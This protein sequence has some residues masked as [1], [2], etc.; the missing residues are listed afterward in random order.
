MAIP[1]KIFCFV[2]TAFMTLSHAAVAQ[3][4]DLG[5]VDEFLGS[6]TWSSEFSTATSM[7]GSW[8]E[9]LPQGTC[10]GY[11]LRTD[12][13]AA[14]GENAVLS[15]WLGNNPEPQKSTLTQSVWEA[16]RGNFI[17]MDFT[18]KQ[19]YGFQMTVHSIE[20][21]TFQVTLNGTPTTLDARRVIAS[22]VNGANQHLGVEYVVVR[23]TRGLGQLVFMRETNDS[24]VEA[25][26]TRL[27]TEIAESM[28][29]E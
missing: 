3:T 6:R 21:T 9:C 4:D 7:T 18:T 10:D 13:A 29:L 5:P 12:V 1:A 23:G 25:I 28:T 15:T 2:F 22:G 20:E 24:P 27:I 17:R 19:S 8:K 11:D 26:R 14:K 16:A